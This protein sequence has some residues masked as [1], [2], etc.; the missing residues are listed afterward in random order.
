MRPT[1][2]MRAYTP[3]IHIPHPFP[4]SNAYE[5]MFVAGS[6]LH[7]TSELLHGVECSAL[8]VG[9]PIWGRGKSLGTSTLPSPHQAKKFVS[10]NPQE[11]TRRDKT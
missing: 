8:P 11:I 9:R 5:R 1:T 10:R 3:T 4:P 2:N 6:S 7:S